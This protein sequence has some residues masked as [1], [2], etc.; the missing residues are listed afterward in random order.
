MID[1]PHIEH[2]DTDGY[3]DPLIMMKVSLYWY[4]FQTNMLSQFN[5]NYS[6]AAQKQALQKV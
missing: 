1:I 2:H 6:I 5:F 3:V 4:Q